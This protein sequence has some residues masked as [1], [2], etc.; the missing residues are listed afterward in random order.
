MRHCKA[1]GES[2]DPYEEHHYCAV[3]TTDERLEYLEGLVV[4]LC[5]RVTELESKS[6]NAP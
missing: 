3:K 4:R 6:E 2:W 5:E 1:C